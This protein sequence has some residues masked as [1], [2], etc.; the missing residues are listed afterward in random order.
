MNN[1]G[2]LCFVGCSGWSSAELKADQRAHRFV[3]IPINV[4]ESVVRE[5]F[6]FNGSCKMTEAEDMSTTDKCAFI[7][8]PRSG[9]KG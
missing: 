4:D 3:P 8:A 2:K 6:R 7:A 5:L 9:A 1:D